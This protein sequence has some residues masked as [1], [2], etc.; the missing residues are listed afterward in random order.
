[1]SESINLRKRTEL[2]VEGFYRDFAKKKIL[3]NNIPQYLSKISLNFHGDI[4]YFCLISKNVLSRKENAKLKSKKNDGEGTNYGVIRV[5][6]DPTMIYQ[7]EFKI[8]EAGVIGI[9]I[10]TNIKPH[11][12]ARN[13]LFMSKTRH[14]HHNYAIKVGY[15]MGW[16]FYEY[17]DDKWRTWT[18]ID[19]LPFSRMSPPSFDKYTMNLNGSTL[20]FKGNDTK[21]CEFE[22]ALE[23]QYYRMCASV[24]GTSTIELTKFEMIKKTGIVVGFFV[25]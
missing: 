9:G 13:S 11:K 21:L 8:N 22:I 6:N 4:E 18:I 17:W 16:I 23:G 5:G 2:L 20:S 3:S 1:M 25:F 14:E 10:T 7:W 19:K 15:N 12:K 24:D